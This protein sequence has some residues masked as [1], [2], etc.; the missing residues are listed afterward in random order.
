MI[1]P[2]PPSPPKNVRICWSCRTT[3]WAGCRSTLITSQ[4]P[5]SAWQQWL[6]EPT[7]ADAIMDRLIHGSRAIALKG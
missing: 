3:A 4:L 5:T 7:I 6:A 1:W 2:S